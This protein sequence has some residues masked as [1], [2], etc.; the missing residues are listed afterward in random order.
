MSPGFQL[1]SNQ[2]SS[3][4]YRRKALEIDPSPEAARDNLKLLG[5]TP[6]RQPFHRLTKAPGLKEPVFSLAPARR[7]LAPLDRR[8]GTHEQMHELRLLRRP[9]LGMNVLQVS[10]GRGLA[11]SQPRSRFLDAKPWRH[12]EQHT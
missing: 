10:L 5:A 1:L 7:L 2:G 11:D 9:G 3:G 6:E 8:R 4:P 12:G